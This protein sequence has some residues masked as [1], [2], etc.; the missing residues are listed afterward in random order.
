MRHTSRIFIYLTLLFSVFFSAT[1]AEEDTEEILEN[2][3]IELSGARTARDSVRILYNIFDISDTR[4]KAE[5]AWVLYDVACRAEDLPA[6]LDMLR[7]LAVFYVRSDSTI[8][9]LIKKTALIPNKDA[10]NST[11]A[12]I[13]NQ[14]FSKMSHMSDRKD[15]GRLLLDSINKSHNIMDN[16]RY[17]KLSLLH[18]LILFLGSDYD[19]AI[20][21]DFFRKYKKMVEDLPLGDYPIKNQYLL[22]MSDIYTRHKQPEKAIDCELQLL[23][24]SDKLTQ[25]NLKKQRKYINYDVVKFRCFERILVNFKALSPQQIEAVHDSM[26]YYYRKNPNVRTYAAKSNMMDAIYLYVTKRYR[27]AIP[28]L[29][30]VLDFNFLPDYQRLNI[31][32]YI[33]ESAKAIGDTRT[34]IMAMEKA[35]AQITH[36]D[37]MRRE[38]VFREASLK[39]YLENKPIFLETETVKEPA[40]AVDALRQ[41]QSQL[42]IVSSVVAILLVI[43]M[44]LYLRARLRQPVRKH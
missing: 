4:S 35:R 23:D 34:Q 24:I 18:Q 38:T 12:F 44:I 42:I 17:D 20:F 36:L 25:K 21:N 37:S 5:T 10:R 32:D 29:T 3:N 13:S 14:Y 9:E 6:Q 22:T 43:Y 16:D 7:N 15:Y 1:A 26:E 27:E 40:P 11:R 33:A 28:A 19:G 41:F 31:Y 39:E 2:L 8:T 30:K